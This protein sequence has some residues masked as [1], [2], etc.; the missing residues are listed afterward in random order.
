MDCDRYLQTKRTSQEKGWD[1]KNRKNIETEGGDFRSG[2]TFE[3]RLFAMQ[4]L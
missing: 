1:S 4:Q 3:T 2:D